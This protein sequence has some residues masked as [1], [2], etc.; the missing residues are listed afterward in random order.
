MN[1][2]TM[3]KALFLFLILLFGLILCSFLGGNCGREGFT[4]DTMTGDNGGV[5]KT[6]TGEQG[7]TITIA[8]GPNGNTASTSSNDA[9]TTSTSD[10][11]NYN[12]YTGDSQ[13]AIFYGPNGSSARIIQT[14]GNDTIVI[15][16]SNGNTEIYYIDKNAQK[17]DITTNTFY[18]PNGSSAKIF[19]TSNGGKALKITMSDGSTYIFTPTNTYNTS[20]MNTNLDTNSTSTSTQGTAYDSA[21]TEASGVIAT[22]PQGNT[23]AVATGPEGNTYAATNYD[24]S[25]YYSSLPPGIPSNQIPLGSE[26]LYILKSQVVPPVCPACPACPIKILD[27]K[28]Q[29]CPAC[30]RCPEPSFDCKKVPNYSSF[31]PDQ[32]PV[33]VMSDFSSFG[34]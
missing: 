20:N 30:A 13:P 19:T 14:N 34:M 15:T 24:S 2:S 9:S 8:A 18:G 3:N 23:A 22:G 1:N 10:Y 27:K 25:D 4:T 33:P 29:P 16:H 26:D 6:I 12:H 28:V 7:N 32:M 11:D 31:N 17:A 21:Y 5:V